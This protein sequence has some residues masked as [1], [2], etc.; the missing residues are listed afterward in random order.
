M[1]RITR[2][3]T[4]DRPATEVYDAIAD[5]A[6]A[7]EWDP[8]VRSSEA[9]GPQRVG[10]GAR[11]D[12]DVTIMGP[13]GLAL[14]YTTT[15]HDRPVRVVHETRSWLAVGVDDV[16][17]S[18]EG[19]V[20]TVSWDAQ[21]SF[22]GRAKLLDDLVQKGFEGVADRA[23]DGLEGWLRAGGTGHPPVDA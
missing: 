4:V 7:Q 12:L 2:S 16:Q 14:T 17:V 6:M 22:G 19:G 18:E 10:V 15:R 1:A 3:F 9:V 21:F 23:V 20:T 5:F 11:F 13:I 8:G